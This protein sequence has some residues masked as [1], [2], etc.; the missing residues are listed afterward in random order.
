M[1]QFFDRYPRGQALGVRRQPGRRH[2]GL[3][4]PAAGR[5]AVKHLPLFFDLSGRKVVV[6]GEGPAA[7]RR[8]ALARSAGALV[9]QLPDVRV[10]D[11]RGAAAVFIATGDLE[12]DT[13]AQR[14]AKSLGVP[15][16]VADRPALCDFIL[17]AI[18]DRDDVVVA[19]ST[20]GASPTLAATLR[21]RIEAVL[22][23]RIGDLAQAGR[24]LPRPGQRPDRR[25]CPP[26][27]LLA[28]AGRG[29]GGAPGPGRRR[30]GCPPRRAG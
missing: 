20:G 8:A 16:N 18:V 15:V 28:P 1:S 21:G 26:P 5:R 24:D 29:T 19:I 22:P 2:A 7:D 23:E 9:R 13:V 27:H 11:L 17:P 14:V 4:R 25:S 3:Q 12:H 6:V 30:C 10:D